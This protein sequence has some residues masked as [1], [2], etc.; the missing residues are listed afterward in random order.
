MVGLWVS[1][2]FS[3]CYFLGP[4]I[5]RYG[6]MTLLSAVGFPLAYAAGAHLGAATLPLGLLSLIAIGLGH[7]LMLPLLCYCVINLKET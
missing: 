4:Y 7:G 3:V 5:K 1:F 2:G 6:L